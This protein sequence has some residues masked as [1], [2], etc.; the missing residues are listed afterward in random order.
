MQPAEGGR[1]GHALKNPFSFAQRDIESINS[2]TN[3]R[4]MLFED[5]GRETELEPSI[6][7]RLEN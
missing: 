2:A 4:A 3:V 6:C 1:W 7:G 5:V